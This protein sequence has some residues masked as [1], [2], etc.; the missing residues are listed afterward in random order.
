MVLSAL[1]VASKVISGE[2]LTHVMPRSCARGRVVREAKVRDFVGGGVWEVCSSG[3]SFF[4][5]V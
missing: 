1:P 4:W 5:G 2:N 3:S